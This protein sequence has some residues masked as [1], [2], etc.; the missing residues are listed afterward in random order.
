MLTSAKETQK[1][2]F[3]GLLTAI[4]RHQMVKISQMTPFFSS[5]LR[6]ESAGYIRFCI[7]ESLKFTCKGGTIDKPKRPL[8]GPIWAYTIRFRLAN[9]KIRILHKISEL[10]V[11]DTSGNQNE[12]YLPK[13][14]V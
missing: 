3:L 10:L 11:Y 5:S 8:L 12:P 9:I 1:G 2:H 13:S 7:L 6:A 14:G 4:T